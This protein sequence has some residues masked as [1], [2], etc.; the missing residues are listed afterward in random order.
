MHMVT[1]SCIYN[2]SP[3]TPRNDE[4]VQGQSSHADKQS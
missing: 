4:V 1:M 2:Q 3:H